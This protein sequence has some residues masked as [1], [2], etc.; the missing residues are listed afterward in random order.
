[1]KIWKRNAIIAAAL[2]LVCGGIWLNW[3]LGGAKKTPLVETLNQEKVLDDTAL[4]IAQQETPLEAAANEPAKKSL[5]DYF[6]QMRLSRQESR[7]S[8][9]ELLQETIAYAGEGED[10]SASSLQLNHL[11][12]LALDEAQIESL[13]ISK[14]YADCVAYMS[15]E[16]ISLA[17]PAGAEGLSDAEVALL[18]DI[19]TSQSDYALKQIRIIEVK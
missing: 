3:K 7:D 13:V 5:S 15:D 9:L 8:A 2:V 1:M 10:V 4:V 6:A 14:G 19:I 18:T 16:G 17:V 12:Q 11:V